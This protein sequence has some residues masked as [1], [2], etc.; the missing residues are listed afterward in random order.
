MG[1]SNN[2]PQIML[3]IYTLN[4]VAKVKIILCIRHISTLNDPDVLEE[5]EIISDLSLSEIHALKLITNKNQ[6]NLNRG[7][8]YKIINQNTLQVS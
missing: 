1:K 5:K 4:Q 3:E 6:T 2:L 7:A 8:L